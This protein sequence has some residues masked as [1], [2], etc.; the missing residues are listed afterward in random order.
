[1]GLLVYFVAIAH[2]VYTPFTKVEESFNMQAMHDILY[3]RT[4]ISMVR[5]LYRYT[6]NF[7]SIFTFSS[8]I[9][10]NTPVQC[11]EPFQVHQL[12]QRWHLQLYW[13]LKCLMY[14]NSGLN[15]LVKT[16]QW[17]VVY[18]HIKNLN[19]LLVRLILAAC[20]VY[21]WSKLR[22]TLQLKLGFHIS[23][24][25]TLITISQFHFMFYTSR[26]LPN[27]MA[28]PFGKLPVCFRNS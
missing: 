27:I 3:H 25:Y 21:S 17:F 12:F 10:T 9:I 5:L 1:M 11:P 18:N 26:P 24:W 4:N 20:V 6:P 15:T 28:L 2:M 16:K 14:E 7:S 23:I 13:S 22:R 19:L 8:T